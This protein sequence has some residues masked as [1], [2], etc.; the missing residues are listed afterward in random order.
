MR[1]RHS[2]IALTCNRESDSDGKALDV[3]CPDDKAVKVHFP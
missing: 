2:G 3:K 1:D